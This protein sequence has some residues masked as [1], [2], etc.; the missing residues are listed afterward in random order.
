MCN[1]NI[2]F[3]DP[4]TYSDG[5]LENVFWFLCHSKD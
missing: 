5:S 2:N 3:V 4:I 1:R